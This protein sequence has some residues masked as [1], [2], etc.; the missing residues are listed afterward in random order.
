MIKEICLDFSA[1]FGVFTVVVMKRCVF[2]D[3]TPNN[4]LEGSRRFGAAY[5]LHLQG[6]KVSRA[7]GQHEANSKQ[8]SAYCFMMMEPICSFETP[9]NFQWNR[10]RF[11]PENIFF[12]EEII[13]HDLYSRKPPSRLSVFCNAFVEGDRIVGWGSIF[14][15]MALRLPVYS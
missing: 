5:G 6:R 1:G 8:S 13:L 10:L 11:I 12:I 7:R 9:V 14:L 4:P 2:W 15:I 3:I